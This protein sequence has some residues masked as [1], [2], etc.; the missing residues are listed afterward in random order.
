MVFM[1]IKT[2]MEGLSLPKATCVLGQS[3]FSLGAELVGEREG[4]RGRKTER[5]GDRRRETERDGERRRER[6]KGRKR[7][8]KNKGKREKEKT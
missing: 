7:E 8:R 4:E 3:S 2:K 1:I 5:D 6:E